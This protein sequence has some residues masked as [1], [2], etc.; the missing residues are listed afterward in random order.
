MPESVLPEKRAVRRSFERAAATYDSNNVL[1]CEVGLRLLRHFDPIR[2]APRRVVDVGCGTGLFF[3]ELRKRFRGAD[4][5][6]IDI[7]H[8]MLLRAARRTPDW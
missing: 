1:Q 4:M 7:A 2:I 6:G 8:P 3:G 5:V